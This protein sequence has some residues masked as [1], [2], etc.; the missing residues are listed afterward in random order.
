VHPYGQLQRIITTRPTDLYLGMD[1]DIYSD[2]HCQPSQFRRKNG[3][4]LQPN[5]VFTA[6]VAS[7]QKI[8]TNSNKNITRFVV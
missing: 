2:N 1:L 8:N 7:L 6:A 4:S 3:Q 5:E